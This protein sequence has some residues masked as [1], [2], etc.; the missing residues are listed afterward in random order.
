MRLRIIILVLAI[1]AVLSASA[2]GGL[3][4]HS[5]KQ[6]AFQQAENHANRRLELFNRQLSASLSEHVKP[7]KALAG[8]QELEYALQMAN[9]NA[10]R[11]TI[12]NSVIDSTIKLYTLNN[13]NSILDNFANA[14]NIEVCY[15][16]NS[17]GETIASSN[18]N[19]PDS[20]VGKNFSFR[21]YFVEAVEGR[22][23]TYLA[24]GTTSNKRGVYY[25][26][27][28]YN[29]QKREIIGVAVIKA[30][31]ELI[32]S[33][34]FADSE[35]ILLVTDPN[36]VIFI[37]N[38][39]ELKLTLLWK[40]D[41]T[42]IQKINETRQ[43][44]D[45]NWNWSGFSPLNYGYVIDRNRKKYLYS[46]MALDGYT[47]WKIVHLRS[48]QEISKEL[49][50]PFLR[51]IGQII[52]II[53]IFI[54]ISVF[55]LYKKAI[56]E[57][58]KRKKAENE[59]RLSEARY[60][61][62]YHNTPVMLH[63]IDT[64]GKII[65]VSDFW[66]EKMGYAR[67]EVV[68][69]TLTD[70]YSDDS[71]KYAEEVVFPYFFKTGFCKDVPYTYL[72]Q[73]GE[74]IEILL[75]CYGVRDEEGKVVRSLAV[76]VDVTEKNQ[77]QHDLELARERLSRYSLDLEQQVE[78][79]TEEVRRVQ[80]QLRKLSGNIM[81]AHENERRAVAR[82]LHDHLG[83]VLTA[84]KMDGVWLEKYLEPL[85]SNAAERASRIC[86]LIDDTIA[87]VRAMAFRLRPGLLD[88]LG[89]VDALESLIRD[90]EKRSDIWFLFRHTEIPEIDDA[91][92]T[93]LYRIA[94]EAL[95]NA[96]KHSKA[97]EI[98][99][100]LSADSVGLSANFKTRLSLTIEDNG[101]GFS[102][103]GNKEYH[104]LGLTG[105]KERATLAG[106]SLDIFSAPD[107]GTKIV[108]KLDIKS[109]C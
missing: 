100:D 29:S 104:G 73:N 81:A 74:K 58:S 64:D 97:T 19:D 71:K 67:D 85:D 60:R 83:Q 20:F 41:K 55:I 109:D 18:R 78:E 93:A 28:V 43:F 39:Q 63:S 33:K 92:A 56:Q 17:K 12:G 6:A 1:L 84:L 61:H 53:S 47:G 23:F 76:S 77:A 30:S 101:C 9:L 8:L 45:I 89:L 90:F 98:S 59:L 40:L 96:L 24:L 14:L 7:V 25:S 87:D 80:D 51:V 108:C 52:I 21:P 82:E 34:L 86:S 50:Q 3:Y 95:T 54:G 36:G 11:T 13:L 49:A 10:I 72:K 46:Q 48:L 42:E 16:L 15:L 62:I 99:V 57:I 32:E 107:K 35:G 4:Y 88:D 102:S 103:V 68:G 66:L 44:G 75:S 31:V 27:H 91:F 37:S 65:G 69:K 79:R 26:H 22:P 94:Q 5:L 106:G 38:S 2:G 105:M 70:F